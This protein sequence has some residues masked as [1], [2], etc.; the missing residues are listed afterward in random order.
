LAHQ[1]NL[2]ELA[3]QLEQFFKKQLSEFFQTQN[4]I[5]LEE[6]LTF[7]Y[8]IKSP[9]TPEVKCDRVVIFRA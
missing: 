2:T 9:N 1:E 5:K 8:R 7:W 3:Q 4:W 6:L